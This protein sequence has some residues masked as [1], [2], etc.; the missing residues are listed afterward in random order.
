[1]GALLTAGYAAAASHAIASS[2]RSAQVSSSVQS[3]LTKSFDG[4][5]AIAMQY[6]QYSDQI[7]S[8]AKKSF[9]H[10]QHWAYA[11]GIIAVLAGA[12]VVRCF[13]PDIEGEK[14]LLASYEREDSA[15]PD[16]ARGQSAPSGV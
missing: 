3:E 10:G 4:A 1:M 9:L 5:T 7:I 2:P 13:F 15:R 8:A 14:E 11:A 12:V 16:M 6:P